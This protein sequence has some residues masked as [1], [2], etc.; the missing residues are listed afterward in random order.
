MIWNWKK[1]T[2]VAYN[3]TDFTMEKVHF[4]SKDSTQIPMVI[5][6]KKGLKKNGK[7]PALLYG[8]GGFG[9]VSTPFFDRGFLS[10]LQNGGIVA[11]P[12]L[13]GGGEF[14]EE[15]HKG[16]SRFNKQNVFDDFTGAAE[17]LFRENYTSKENLAI[18]GGSN[19]GLLVAAVL[20]QKPDICKVAISE[21]G[22]YDML[23]YQKYTIGHAWEREYGS[24]DDSTQFEYLYK[25][26][27]LHNVKDTSYPA[28]LVI[29]ADHDDRVVP[30]HSFK[31]VAAMQKKNTGN[32]PILLYIQKNSGHQ[33]P[34]LETQAYIYSFIYDQLGVPPSKI[35]TLDY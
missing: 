31:Y 2:K 7:N 11:L 19:G 26:S 18:M 6:Y 14:G 23:R 25:Y 5:A 24:S 15:W 20:N 1:Q 32:N 33:Q 3:Y 12:C 21:V 35:H 34:N 17:Y 4:Y 16:G 13:R 27:P 28:V 30:L 10:F 22:V 29:T 9:K 8:Y